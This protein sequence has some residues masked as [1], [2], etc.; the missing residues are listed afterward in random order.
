MLLPLGKFI[1]L[2]CAMNQKD[3]ISRSFSRKAARYE[4]H[5]SI[6]RRCIEKLLAMLHTEQPDSSGRWLDIGGG[7]GY[8]AKVLIQQ[9]RSPSLYVSQDF[10]FDT[11]VQA[12]ENPVCVGLCADMELRCVKKNSFDRVITASSLQWTY[13]PATVIQNCYDSLTPDGWLAFSLFT[14]GSLE[15]LHSLQQQWGLQSITTYPANIEFLNLLEHAG[16][17]IIDSAIDDE[18]E[19]FS[20][21]REAL[22][23]LSAIG[24]TAVKG[25]RLS[26]SELRSFCRLY[27]TQCRTEDG[28]YIH[29]NVLRGIGRKNGKKS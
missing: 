4:Y 21:G 14:S 7:I 3:Q 5:S 20:S 19:Y 12:G 16:F 2:S 6:Q 22:R 18:K 11:L 25:R 9:D 29:Y 17:A 10:A 23:S 1:Y 13:N 15:A 26:P 24:A 28:V 8:G 27:E